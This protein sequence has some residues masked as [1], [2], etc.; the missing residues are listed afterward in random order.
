VRSIPAPEKKQTVAELRAA[1]EQAQ[2]IYLTAFSGLTVAQAA[3]LRARVIEAGARLR[4]VKNRLFRLALQGTEF[5]PLVEHLT[6]PNAATF[7]AEDALAPV[8]ALTE[9]AAQHGQPPVKA[10]LVEGRL[11]SAEQAAALARVPG[12]DQLVAS[13]VGAVAGPVTDFVFTLSGIVSEFVFTLQAV[14]D[15]RG[16]QAA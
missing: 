12:R 3:E 2:S 10:G 6:G 14:A 5:E 4:V 7:C 9:F 16:E 1:A 13:V 15:Q 8:K 11:I